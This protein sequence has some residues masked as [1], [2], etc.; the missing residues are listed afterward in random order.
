M[1]SH[2]PADGVR[3]VHKYEVDTLG[4]PFKVSVIDAVQIRTDPKT[5]KDMIKIPDLVGLI[6]VV[7]RTRVFDERKLNGP[8]LKF[9]RKAIGVRSNTLAEFLDM[10]PEHL[11]R[12][13]KGSK[14][15]TVTSEKLFRL[16]I[17]LAT[18]VDDPQKMLEKFENIEIT[19]TSEEPAEVAKKFISNFLSMK[20]RSVFDL[21]DELH[22]EFY[23]AA[24]VE[25]WSP[26]LAA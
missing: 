7:V 18:Y 9:L 10:T 11:S 12:C 6:N 16:F 25:K 14:I 21:G 20:I 8:E 26:S 23:R 24:T 13:E 15:M 1:K 17:F 2:E 5:G 19:K 4:A 3:N 22:Y